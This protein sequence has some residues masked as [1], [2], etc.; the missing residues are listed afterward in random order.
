MIA[1]IANI[2]KVFRDKLLTISTGIVPT[3]RE[4][5]IKVKI[6]LIGPWKAPPWNSAGVKNK[7]KSPPVKY[8]ASVNRKATED[9]I[10]ITDMN[11]KVVI[12]INIIDRSNWYKV[13][14]IK[15]P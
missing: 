8:V 11:I 4:G 1:K 15:N 9:I 7:S 13:M 3:N 6:N 2:N 14:W 5:I 12:I 10:V